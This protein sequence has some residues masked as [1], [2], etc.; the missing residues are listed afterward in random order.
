MKRLL[1]PMAFGCAWGLGLWCLSDPRLVSP[2]GRTGNFAEDLF[3]NARKAMSEQFVYRAD[4]YFHGGVEHVECDGHEL[5]EHDHDHG[6]DSGLAVKD[7]KSPIR[8]DWFVRM[9][10]T[11]R[12][13]GHRHL[14]GTRYEKEVLPW[15]WVALKAD[16]ANVEAALTTSYWLARLDRPEEALHVLET[17]IAGKPGAASLELERGRL[18]RHQGRPD[19]A[20]DALLRGY[21][22][23]LQ[24]APDTDMPGDEDELLEVRV[25]ILSYLSVID[26]ERGD[27]GLALRRV[28]EAIDLRPEH[29]GLRQRRQLLL[30]R[31]PTS[32]VTE[33]D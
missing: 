17:A 27:R 14:A 16:P 33:A 19:Q 21:A 9:H 26:E 11:L 24:H 6:R 15:L 8:G 12:P 18:L 1:V 2:E 30:E 13:G 7:A 5:E 22:K 28:E 29:P 4:V 10:R 3:G 31:I 32:A 23:S 20:R 25:R